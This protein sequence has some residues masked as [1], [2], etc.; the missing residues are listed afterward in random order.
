MVGDWALIHPGLHLN[1][2]S[3][4]TSICTASFSRTLIPRSDLAVV[5]VVAYFSFGSGYI[6]TLT[7]ELAGAEAGG[8]TQNAARKEEASHLLNLIFQCGMTAATLLSIVVAHFIP[9]A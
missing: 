8:P 1:F 3:L 2:H 7:I 4:L 9:E 6:N 5:A